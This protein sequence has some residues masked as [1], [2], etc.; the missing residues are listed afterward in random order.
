M[1]ICVYK[2]FLSVY[3]FLANILILDTHEIQDK[4]NKKEPLSDIQDLDV[5]YWKR[6]ISLS[7]SSCQS[8]GWLV[9]RRSG[10]EPQYLPKKLK[11]LNNSVS[12]LNFTCRLCD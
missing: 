5:S 12:K 11:L 4:E 7:E 6:K 10:L 9:C 2:I 1:F 3:T 8:V